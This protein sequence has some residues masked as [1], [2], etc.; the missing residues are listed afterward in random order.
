MHRVALLPQSGLPWLSPLSVHIFVSLTWKVNE[1]QIIH[2]L[3]T[4]LEA[5][6]V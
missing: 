2:V 1:G 4:D 6:R 3:P 5:D